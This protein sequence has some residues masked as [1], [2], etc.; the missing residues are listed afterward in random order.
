M[1][2]ILSSMIAACAIVSFLASDAS[3]QSSGRGGAN[4]RCRN[5]G[6]VQGKILLQS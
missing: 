1:R 5:G 6:T 2:K 3:A 4:A